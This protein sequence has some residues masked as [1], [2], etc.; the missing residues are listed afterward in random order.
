MKQIII[1]LG[2]FSSITI[3]AQQGLVGVGTDN[4]KANLDIN[5]DFNYKGKLF[6]DDGKGN[7]LAG[8]DGQVLVSQGL[9]KAPT[10]K[11]FRV[12]DYEAEKYYLIFNESFKNFILKNGSLNDGGGQTGQGVTF[13]NSEVSQVIPST[14]LTKGTLLSTLTNSTN[15]FKI[16]NDLSQTFKVSSSNSKT[17]FLFETVVQ[18]NNSTF[19]ADSTYACG[20]F[21]DDKLESIRINTY[22]TN[23]V[24]NGFTTHTQIGGIDNLSPGNNHTVAVACGWLAK[25]SN[26]TFG[27]GSPASDKNL[28]NLDNF[29]SQSSLKIDVYEVPEKFS[30]IIK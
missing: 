19:Y 10:W 30:P 12:P 13:S 1:V 17:Y 26:L 27:I 25:S 7:L 14:G 23:N 11:T 6:L 16:I 20:I 21:V 29:M 9:G 2:L 22:S 3:S 18:H 15:K 8:Q 4:P 28:D 24:A 5:G